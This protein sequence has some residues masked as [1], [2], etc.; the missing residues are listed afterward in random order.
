MYQTEFEGQHHEL[1]T[2]GFLFR[3]NKLMYDAETKSLWST[4]QGKPV[5]GP[6]VGKGI[7]LK[8]HSL[9]TTTWGEWRRRHPDTTVLPIAT[10]HQRDYS[11]GTAYRKY[12]SEQKLMFTV[13]KDDDRLQNK[14]EVVAL[15]SSGKQLAVSADY[16]MNHKVYQNEVGNIEF[17]ILTDASGANRV[18]ETKGETFFWWD[19][20]GQLFDQQQQRWI[21]TEQHLIAPDGMRSL[22]RVPAHRAFW[23]GWHSQFPQTQL[24]K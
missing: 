15:R 13:P 23:F 20:Q 1:G 17:V 21:V 16:L 2:S 14:D 22:Q 3:S 24:I 5:V 4:L 18:Y 12:F 7:K 8:R 6:L 19:E 11:E 9:V 10:G